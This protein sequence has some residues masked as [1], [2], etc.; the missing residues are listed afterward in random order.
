MSDSA[1]LR[2]DDGFSA[3]LRHDLDGLTIGA[4]ASRRQRGKARVPI[5]Q[6]ES[7]LARGTAQPSPRATW[8]ASPCRCALPSILAPCGTPGLRGAAPNARPMV[9][10]AAQEF[11]DECGRV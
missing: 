7:W 1:P 9:R 3:P 11:P 6:L 5:C 8:R 2:E 4:D 10:G